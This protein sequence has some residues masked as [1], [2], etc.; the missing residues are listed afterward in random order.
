M[1]SIYYWAPF[2]SKVATIDAVI[3][4]AE[5]INKY[6]KKYEATIINAIGEFDE[7]EQTLKKKKINVIN[8]QN[9]V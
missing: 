8:L 4:S 6:S 3:N 2:T 7:Y 5:A 9:I 1:K